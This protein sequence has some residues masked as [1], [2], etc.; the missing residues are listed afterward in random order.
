MPPL[1]FESTIS[2]GERPQTAGGHRDRQETIT[3]I[4]YPIRDRGCV[5]IE[6]SELNHRTVQWGLLSTSN[7][8]SDPIE[9]E[10]FGTYWETANKNLHPE[11]SSLL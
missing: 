4:K 10:N 6:L 8:P 11:I 1:G 3:Y 9:G 5:N 2:T 7:E